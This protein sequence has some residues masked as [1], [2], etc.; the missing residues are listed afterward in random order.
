MDMYIGK[1]IPISQL[2]AFE[3]LGILV[4]VVVPTKVRSKFM[5]K[6]N[7]ENPL[8]RLSQGNISLVS[9]NWCVLLIYQ[10]DQFDSHNV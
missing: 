6:R 10:H 8:L 9:V 7:L 3:K 5:M 2:G 1:K 4:M